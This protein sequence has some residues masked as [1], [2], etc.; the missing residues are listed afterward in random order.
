WGRTRTR[1]AARPPARAR[2]VRD[3]ARA[4]QRPAGALRERRVPGARLVRDPRLR[5]PDRPGDAAPLRYRGLHGGPWWCDG[6]PL[7]ASVGGGTMNILYAFVASG[8]VGCAV[9][10]VLSRNIVRLLLGLSL[11]TTAVNRA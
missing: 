10:M 7:R 5:D 1:D 2:A 11:M 6:L 3:P 9:Y 4:R 8:L